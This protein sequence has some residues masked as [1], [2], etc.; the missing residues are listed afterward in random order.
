V[1]ESSEINGSTASFEATFTV[2]RYE[3]SVYEVSIYGVDERENIAVQTLILS[4]DRDPPQIDV[5]NVEEIQRVSG[6]L[7]SLECNFTDP[8]G[9][10]AVEAYFDG[11]LLVF[12]RCSKTRVK[13]LVRTFDLSGYERGN[14]VI[15]LKVVDVAGNVASRDVDFTME[16]N[17]RLL[18]I[19]MNVIGLILGILSFGVLYRLK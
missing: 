10:T 11:D 9:I 18:Y 2:P 6:S 12:D 19:I 5:I 17:G 13:T 7:L 4:S 15:T 3:E 16:D 8:T 1:Y 14:H